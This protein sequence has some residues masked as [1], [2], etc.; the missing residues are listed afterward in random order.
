M[1]ITASFTLLAMAAALGL[2]AC[3]A[4]QRHEGMA[5]QR[6]ALAASLRP[7]IKMDQVKVDDLGNGIRVRITDELLYV[8]GSVEIDAK[9]RTALGKVVSQ[10]A[11]M[12][13]K[14]YEIDVVGHTDN[15]PVGPRLAERYPTNWELAAARAT[16][17]V[18]FLQDNGVNPAKLEAIS[19]G[20]YHPSASNDSVAGR[21]QNRSTDLVLRPH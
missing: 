1:R 3:S 4:R 7:E 15:V 21:A 6:D 13:A 9:G 17:V 2:S 16:L 11:A 5:E 19:D 12:A 20:E 8:P 10:L 18:R 14:D